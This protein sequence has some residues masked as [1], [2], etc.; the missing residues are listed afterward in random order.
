MVNDGVQPN[1]V[2]II[3]LFLQ[4]QDNP[5]F[6]PCLYGIVRRLTYRFRPFVPKVKFNGVGICEAITA[7]SVWQY[8]FHLPL[9]GLDNAFQDAAALPGPWLPIE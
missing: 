1:P 4:Y 8:H 3:L 2:F 7:G 5:C 9:I 6:L